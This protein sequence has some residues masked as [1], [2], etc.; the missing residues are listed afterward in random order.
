M[1]RIGL[2]LAGGGPLGAVY[3]IGA[4]AAIA[5]SVEGLDLN[6]ADIYV[7]ISAGGIIAA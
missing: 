5:E 6:D 7:G 2:A 3:E 4:L 1:P